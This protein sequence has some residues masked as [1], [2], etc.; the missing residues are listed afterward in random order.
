[1]GK[2]YKNI[3]DL[4]RSELIEEEVVVPDF[5]KAN[6]DAALGFNKTKKY[7]FYLSSFLV[8]IVG[9]SLLFFHS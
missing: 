2:E 9:A 7:F 5:V 6:I 1:M 8:L 3:D 4:F